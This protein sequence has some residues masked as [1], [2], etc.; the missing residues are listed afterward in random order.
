M[1]SFANV[2]LLVSFDGADESTTFTDLSNAGRTLTALN[3]AQLDTSQKKYGTA[4]GLFNGTTDSV[5]T[6]ASSDLLIGSQEF[7]IEAWIRPDTQ[8]TGKIAGIW[9]DTGGSAFSYAFYTLASG[10]IVFAWSSNGSGSSSL[11]STGANYSTG[12]FSHVAVDRDS[13]DTLRLFLNGVQVGSATVSDTFF[14]VASSKLFEIGRDG[15]GNTNYFRGRMDDLRV[16][17]GESVYSSAFTPPSSAHPTSDPLAVNVDVPGPLAPPE[18]VALYVGSDRTAHVSVE[19]PLDAP[20]IVAVTEVET[21]TALVSVSSVLAGPAVIGLN[22]FTALITDTSQ[23]YVMRVTGPSV[24]ELPI[25]S[26][27]ATI[28]TDRQDFL[29][30]VVPNVTAFADEL[31]GRVGVEIFAI[32]RL[33]YIENEMIESQMVSAPLTTLTVN[34]GPFN[35]TATLSGYSTAAT[36]PASGIVSVS[37]VRQRFNTTSGASR[38]RADINWL[39]RPGQTADAGDF[40]LRADYI[41]YFVPAAGDSYMDVGSRG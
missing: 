5:N 22:D 1:P 29:Q 6:P 4:S 7:C 2:A 16:T 32:Y 10:E 38:I 19:S 3:N 17:I 15:A 27:Q 35:E 31:A 36:V 8:H 30:C 39:L 12:V 9:S 33:G 24:L 26:W 20:D 37:G 28:Q 18:I 23:R 11:A 21:R 34:G 25:S 14:A 13:S 40:S 41:N